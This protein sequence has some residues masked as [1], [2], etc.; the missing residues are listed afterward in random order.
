MG[1]LAAAL[2]AALLSP[3]RADAQFV[4]AGAG[5]FSTRDYT[6]PVLE[7][8][9]GTPA[10]GPVR[11]TVITSFSPTRAFLKPIIIPQIGADLVRFPWVFGVDV[12]AVWLHWTD[13]SPDPNISLRVFYL[14]DGPWSAVLIGSSPLEAWEGS[15]V[16][17]F[18]RQ[19]WWRG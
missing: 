2:G 9:A 5:I 7:V 15:I 11:A 17:K 12:G 14:T 10:L 3:G 13:Q 6:E 1:G 19:L 18:N 8:V 4:V 16:L